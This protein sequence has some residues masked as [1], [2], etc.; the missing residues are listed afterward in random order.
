M[1]RHCSLNIGLEFA[2]QI[3]SL[4]Y[5]QA[6]LAFGHEIA[7]RFSSLDLLVRDSLVLKKGGGVLRDEAPVFFPLIP[8]RLKI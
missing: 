3:S 2:K 4:V 8:E 1:R 6:L 5:A 7:E